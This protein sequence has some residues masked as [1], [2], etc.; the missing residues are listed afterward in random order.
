MTVEIQE[1]EFT[2]VHLQ[3]LRAMVVSWNGSEFGAPTIEPTMPYGK[4]DTLGRLAKMMGRDP[5]NL[6]EEEEMELQNLHRQSEIAF[7]IFLVHG[8]LETGLYQFYD[9]LAV[10]HLLLSDKTKDI[11]IRPDSTRQLETLP[12]SRAMRILHIFKNLHT[13]RNDQERQLLK[14]DN[15][16][17]I[18]TFMVLED[19]LKL[20]QNLSVI[21]SRPEKSLFL[22]DDGVIEESEHQRVSWPVVGIDPKHPYGDRTDCIADMGKI[23]K[24]SP[25]DPIP[26]TKEYN[27]GKTKFK[28]S[29]VQQD[30]LHGLHSDMQTVLQIFLQKGEI[31]VGRYCNTTNGWVFADAMV[32]KSHHL[33]SISTT[34]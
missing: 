9:H 31:V 30:I 24:M 33:E 14:F 26:N 29:E 3:M 6:V 13:E 18:S 23:L 16:S 10:R 2:S 4:F 22:S 28:Y 20:L 8:T 17:P 1:F 12:T 27:G 11:R 21:W 32:Q 15:P 19:H 25:Q 34:R 7:K 5:K